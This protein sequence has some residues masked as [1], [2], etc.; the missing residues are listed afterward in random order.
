MFIQ[1]HKC[2]WFSVSFT[3]IKYGFTHSLFINDSG[4][5]GLW[6]CV[7][8]MKCHMK[9]HLQMLFSTVILLKNKTFKAKVSS[10]EFDR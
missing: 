2:A 6:R 4:K 7:M 8:L 3:V 10:L 5:V 9:V 1:Q